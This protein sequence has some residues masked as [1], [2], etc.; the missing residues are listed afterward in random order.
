F[1]LLALMNADHD[2]CC[3]L[4]VFCVWIMSAIAIRVESMSK[5]YRIGLE[6]QRHETLMGAVASFIRSPWENYRNLR[7]LSRFDDVSAEAGNQKS[8][9]RSSD[10]SFQLSA[11][12]YHPHPAAFIPNRS[13]PPVH[14]SAFIPHPAVVL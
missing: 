12:N 7:K 3:L 11:F 14:P 2:F 13:K 10:T 8:A 4:S 1:A 5:A 9:N 6:E